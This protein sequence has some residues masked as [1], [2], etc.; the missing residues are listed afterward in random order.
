MRKFFFLSL[1]R[2]EN[3]L[4]Q[5][6][7]VHIKMYLLM[8]TSNLLFNFLPFAKKYVFHVFGQILM[9]LLNLWKNNCSINIGE[10]LPNI[11]FLLT[12]N[13]FLYEKIYIYMSW[14]LV[15]YFASLTT[16]KKYFISI[17]CQPM[18]ILFGHILYYFYEQC[19]LI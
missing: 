19:W 17:C 1:Y 16:L 3:R 18:P 10:K 4:L 12:W 11:F 2:R 9:T 6:F 5:D 15:F 8:S 7:H 13:S 14:C